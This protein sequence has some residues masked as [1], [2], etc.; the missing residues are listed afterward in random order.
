MRAPWRCTAT[1]HSRRC[2][3]TTAWWV[4]LFVCLFGCTL[5]F[6]EHILCLQGAPQQRLRKLIWSGWLHQL[7]N[8]GSID[9]KGV[10]WRNTFEARRW[11]HLGFLPSVTSCSVNL[12]WKLPS[13]QVCLPSCEIKKQWWHH[14]Q[15]LHPSK[16]RNVMFCNLCTFCF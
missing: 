3:A 6:Y 15:K 5:W 4:F 11:E 9:S 16:L 8:L 12:K 13:W 1:A 14:L 10:W 2:V 7:A